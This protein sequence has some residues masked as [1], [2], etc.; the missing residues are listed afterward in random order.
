VTDHI[1]G[2][3]KNKRDRYR[4]KRQ[5]KRSVLSAKKHVRGKNTKRSK[6][7]NLDQIIGKHIKNNHTKIGDPE[8]LQIHHIEYTVDHRKDESRPPGNQAKIKQ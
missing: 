7:G 4:K 3:R 8:P 6:S 5:Q 1:T 2:E